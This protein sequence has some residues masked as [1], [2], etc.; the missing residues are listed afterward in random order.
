[1]PRNFSFRLPAGASRDPRFL[2]R[3]VIGVL[4]VANLFAA[5]AVFQPLGGSAEEL[6]EQVSA[7]RL[8]IQ[9][10]QA[11]LQRMRALVA[12]IEQARQSG[13]EFLG[14][15]FMDRQTMSSTIVQELSSAA[16]EA[17]MRPK[18][19]AFAFDPVE[20]SDTLSMM[21]VTG[22]YEGTYGDLLQF[23]NRLDKS[24]RFLILDT[25]T[26]TP[27]QGGAALNVNVK[28]NTFVRE[29]GAGQAAPSI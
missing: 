27:Q 5:Y 8:Q 24:R 20:G 13:D 18:E 12:K 25:L 16:K 21:T 4:L 23:V 14:T 11:S 3:V 17:G 1:M 28:L 9:Q 2:A 7:M 15:Y 19:H 26:A 10:R 6:D 22:N 29:A